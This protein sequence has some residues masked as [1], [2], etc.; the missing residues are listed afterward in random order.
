MRRLALLFIFLLA[1]M[2]PISG[3]AFANTTSDYNNKVAAAK[4]KIATAEATLATLQ[5]QLDALNSSSSGDAELLASAQT[6][7]T[8]AED[9]LELAG[10][11]YADK[12]GLYDNALLAVENAVDA[13]NDAG[14]AVS[15]AADVVESTYEDYESAQLATDTA[16]SAVNEAQTAYDASATTVGG[17]ASP[18][19]TM[20]VY[21]GIQSY[22]NPPQRSDSLYTLCR[23]ATVTHIADNWGGSSVA[24]CNSEY[25]MI[26]YTGYITYPEAKSVYFFAQA[27]DGFYMT[28]NGQPIVNDWSLK[29]CSGNSAGLFTFEA[30]KSYAIDAWFY[31]WTGGAC[32]T[33]FHQPVGS[34]QWSVT[35]ASM[36]STTPV[37]VTSKDPALKAVL[38]QKTALYVDAVAAEESLQVVYSDAVDAY[39]ATVTVFEDAETVLDDKQVVLADADSALSIIEADWQSKSDVYSDA[40]SAYLVRKQQFEILFNQLKAK[41]LEVDNARLALESA[42]AEL[43]AIPKPVAPAKVSKKPVVKPTPSVKP[44]PKQVFVPDP[45]K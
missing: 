30:N 2:L 14:L 8:V 22:G 13:V 9:E 42:K 10:A 31:E 17:Q 25:V 5:G 16:L 11:A 3:V 36:F 12:R 26:H 38:E 43:A 44:I 18:G 7:V 28:I 6:A 19:L 35:P 29:G 23:T 45:K 4:A 1:F 24:G 40:Q 15:E 20:R 32:S 21:N 41:S 34:G 27:D 37:A 33:L 39:D